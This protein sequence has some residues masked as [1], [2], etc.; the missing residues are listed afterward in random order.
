MK[1]G[2]K[3]ARGE[4]LNATRRRDGKITRKFLDGSCWTDQVI[5]DLFFPRHNDCVGLTGKVSMLSR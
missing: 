5:L 3:V 4:R 1:V 2:L